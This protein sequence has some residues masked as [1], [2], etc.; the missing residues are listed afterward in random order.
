MLAE[1]ARPQRVTATRSALDTGSA[2]GM[3]YAMI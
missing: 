3:N 2:S 1:A